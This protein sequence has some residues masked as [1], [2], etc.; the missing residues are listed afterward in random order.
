MSHRGLERQELPNLRYPKGTMKHAGDQNCLRVRA[1]QA[2][3]WA[4]K[5]VSG[6]QV[7]SYSFL[8]LEN[9]QVI[10]CTGPLGFICEEE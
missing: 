10:K 3:A 4:L 8:G 6:I 2:R 5:P 7:P 9:G 1:V